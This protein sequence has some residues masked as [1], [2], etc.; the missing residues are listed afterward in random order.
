M[1]KTPKDDQYSEEETKRRAEDALRGAFKTP[2]V[3]VKGA[4]VSGD[5]RADQ[6]D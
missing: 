5:K 1:S 2:P 4:P 3:R 6:K